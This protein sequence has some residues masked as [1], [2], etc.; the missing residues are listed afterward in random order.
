MVRSLLLAGDWMAGPQWRFVTL[1]GCAHAPPHQ[2][3]GVAGAGQGP[4]IQALWVSLAACSPGG[5][6]LQGFLD[7]VLLPLILSCR[8]DCY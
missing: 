2:A 3:A 1:T 8:T 5:Q 7:A 6:A 4:V